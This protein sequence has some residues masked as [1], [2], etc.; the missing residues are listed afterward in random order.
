MVR[1]ARDYRWS[2]YRAHGEGAPDPLLAGH[3][4]YERIGRTP[5]DRQ[6]AYKALFRT[7]LDRAFVEDLRAATNGGWALGNARFQRQIA[8]ALGRRVTPLPKGRP[9]RA[10]VEQRQLNLL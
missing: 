9:P 5:A 1:H 8:E 6:K 4:L 10:K 7:T 2:S 3:E